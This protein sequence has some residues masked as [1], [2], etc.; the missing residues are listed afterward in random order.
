LCEQ[1]TFN[2]LKEAVNDDVLPLF[3][4]IT[5]V[6]EKVLTEA[7]VPSLVSPTYHSPALVTEAAGLGLIGIRPSGVKTRTSSS[8]RG[9]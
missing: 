4:P 6:S 5:T 2:I 8:L 3:N 1:E 7:P 9:G